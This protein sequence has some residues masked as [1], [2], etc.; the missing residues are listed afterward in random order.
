MNSFF[1]PQLGSQIYTMAGMTTRSTCRPTARH[2]S[3]PVGAVQRRRLSDMHF[4]VDAVPPT[5]FAEWV[6]ATR[7]SRPDARRRATRA[8]QAEQAVAPFTYRLGRSPSLF[9]SIV[10]TRR[11]A[12]GDGRPRARTGMPWGRKMT[13]LG[14]LTW[15]RFPFDQPI[16]LG[17]VGVRGRWSSRGAGWVTRQ[18]LLALSVARVDHQRRSQAHR[19]HVHACWRW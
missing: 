13:M 5:K 4:D 12:P 16:P 1:V 8:G 3:G 14:K 6:D 18:G 17:A 15:A 11:I 2:L 19:R 9:D 10:A 7:S